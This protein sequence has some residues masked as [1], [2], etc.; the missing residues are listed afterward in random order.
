MS[1]EPN[2]QDQVEL[3]GPTEQLE[4]KPVTSSLKPGI[5]SL[6]DNE[7]KGEFNPNTE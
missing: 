1:N 2:V 7:I 4:D 3:E 6:D 5:Q